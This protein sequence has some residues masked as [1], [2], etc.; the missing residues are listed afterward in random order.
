MRACVFR[1]KSGRVGRRNYQLV[2]GKDSLCLNDQVLGRRYARNRFVI[3]IFRRAKPDLKILDLDSALLFWQFSNQI[4]KPIMKSIVVVY[5]FR[6]EE[7]MRGWIVCFGGERTMPSVFSLLPFC[8]GH[9]KHR[10]A[11]AEY[12][13]M[14]LEWVFSKKFVDLVLACLDLDLTKRSTTNELLQ[15]NTFDAVKNMEYFEL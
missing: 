12:E 5:S 1:P 4:S 2:E 15:L 13:Y 7:E 8:F 3:L 9:S 11:P 10:I 14:P 6:K